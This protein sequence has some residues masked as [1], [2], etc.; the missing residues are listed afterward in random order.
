MSS[1][2]AQTG[3]VPPSELLEGKIR[4]LQRRKLAVESG[5]G[6][7]QTATVFLLLLAAEMF[8][9]WRL[10]LPWALR[11]IWLLVALGFVLHL[12]NE[13]VV[14]P[15]MDRIDTDR[16]ALL[17]EKHFPAFNSRLIS[18]LQLTRPGALRGGEAGG[19]VTALIRQTE[20][21]AAKID[22]NSIVRTE[23]LRRRLVWLLGTI[24]IAGILF[25]I[26]G[27]TSGALLQRAF[28]ATSVE[29]PRKT[30]VAEFTGDLVVGR[31]DPVTLTATASGVIP[32]EGSV[33]I[34]YDSGLDRVFTMDKSDSGASYTRRLESVQES[35]DYLVRLN[36]GRS[37]LARIEV[38]PRPTIANLEAR[39]IFPAYTG[40]P[41]RKRT[42][43]DLSLLA[44][45]RLHLALTAN[46]P[47]TNGWLQLHGATNRLPLT[48]GANPTELRGLL[49]ITATNL[50]GFSVHLTDQ[51]GLASQ[52]EAVYRVDVLPDRVP[53]ARVTYPLRREELATAQARVMVAFE[54][55]DDYGI[56]EVRLRYQV[57]DGATNTI[58]LEIPA[59][60]RLVKNRYNFDLKGIQPG[61]VEENSV[62][63]WLEFRDNNNV[64]GPGHT[65]TER[66]VVR[67]VSEDEK[68][69]DLLNRVGDS[70][71]SIGEAATDQ[72][73]LNQ[74]LGDLIQRRTEESV[75]PQPNDE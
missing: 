46:K 52:D 61:L 32:D 15:I 31:G 18:A 47:V 35:F 37:R 71:G 60:Q 34:E 17:V 45:S 33:E 57:N 20:T 69:R 30:R 48:V 53:D 39:Q 25:G 74:R 66:Y 28:L 6:C 72:E 19:L 7:A 8:V 22:F 67:I 26:G 62:H 13:H 38:V 12:F 27:A 9:D 16:A 70:L 75:R 50:I 14:I 11:L 59:G 29:V 63:Y 56:D 54:A 23:G 43:A 68:R 4:D 51:H 58:P 3:P 55:T 1:R 42:A 40:R 10:E 24:G 5:S 2:G 65:A 64:T 44:G 41:E 49:D 21:E 73:S 36:D